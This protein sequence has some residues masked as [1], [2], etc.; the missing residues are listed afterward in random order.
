MLTW[1]YGKFMRSFLWSMRPSGWLL[2]QEKIVNLSFLRFQDFGN[3]MDQ[4]STLVHTRIYGLEY[5]GRRVL[6]VGNGNSGMEIA[7]GPRKSWCSTLLAVCGQ[8]HILP[9]DILGIS[10]FLLTSTL[11]RLRV[12]IWLVYCILLFYAW[13]LYGSL[14]SLGFSRSNEEPMEVKLKVGKT[15]VLDVG[16]LS[17]IKSGLIKVLTGVASFCKKG[18]TFKNEETLHFDTII[19]ATGYKSNM[20]TWL[21]GGEDLFNVSGHPKAAYPGG[22]KGE[23][24]MFAAGL[25]RR[26]LRGSCH[27]AEEIAAEIEKLQLST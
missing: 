3:F 27:D 4:S 16:A 2:L 7:F 20:C 17:Q 1:M 25:T 10:T 21:E 6:V 11:L 5:S 19:M 13:L 15:P 26:G 18:A 22:W 24:G 23:K 8:V 14:S 9:R 12:P